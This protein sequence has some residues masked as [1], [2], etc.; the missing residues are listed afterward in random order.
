MVDSAIFA[1]RGSA[2]ELIDQAAAALPL[3]DPLAELDDAGRAAASRLLQALRVFAVDGAGRDPAETLAELPAWAFQGGKAYR[4]KHPRGRSKKAVGELKEYLATLL[5]AARRAGLLGYAEGDLAVLG[6]VVR[7]GLPEGHSL[8]LVEPSVAL[9]HPI[10]RSLAERGAV[11]ESITVSAG[12]GG[13]WQGL[14]A[15]VAQLEA[16]TGAGI[17]RD[18]VAELARRTLR[19]R[20]WKG[21]VDADSISELANEYRKLAGLAGDGRITRRM[22]E[23]AVQDRG[24]EDVWQI[25]DALGAGRAPEALGRFQRLMA[26]AE[27]AIATRLSFFGLLAGFCRQ[28]A[29]IAGIARLRRVPAG[30]SSY[31]QFKNRC[32][33][34][35]QEPLDWGGKNPLAGLHPYR[36]H[37][38]YL[39]ASR[40]DRDLLPRL[41]WLVLETEMRVKGDSSD[42]DLAIVLLMTEILQAMK[43]K[44]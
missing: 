27:D 8:I 34:K 3:E 41:P 21:A 31:Q 22:V 17:E 14:E 24:Q 2:A 39:A 15:L 38:A 43:P 16:E 36:L 1:D 30:V 29:A 19:V 5:E 18:A 42:P 11:I 44:R 10:V 12:K 26:T 37:R 9:D 33:P 20:G 32:V 25:L 6:E 4:K 28:L 13:R 35:L 23:K 7:G 40:V